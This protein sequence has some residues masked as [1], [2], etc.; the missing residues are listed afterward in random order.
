MPLRPFSL[1][2]PEPGKTKSWEGLEVDDFSRGAFSGDRPL[3]GDKLGMLRKEDAIFQLG[4]GEFMFDFAPVMS[5]RIPVV[6][7]A[8]SSLGR[9]LLRLIGLSL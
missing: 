6:V 4:V 9:L 8:R 3:T 2:V 5:A 7:T 1:S